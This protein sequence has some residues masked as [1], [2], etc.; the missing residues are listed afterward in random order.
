MDTNIGN[1]ETRSYHD[2]LGER[3][4]RIAAQRKER[5][6]EFPPVANV[7][8]GFTFIY[9]T[10]AYAAVGTEL[11]LNDLPEAKPA[12]DDDSG[13]DVSNADIRYAT[14]LKRL[15]E[16]TQDGWHV[17]MVVCLVMY[18]KDVKSFK[19]EVACMC[20][21]PQDDGVNAAMDNFIR[22]MA[23]RIKSG[24]HPGLGL[25]QAEFSRVIK[26]DGQWCLTKAAPLPKR[27][28]GV[29]VFKRKRTWTEYIVGFAGEHQRGCNL[30]AILFWLALIALIVFI[31][32]SVFFR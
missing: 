28:D 24:D 7:Y 25:S 11:S 1:N 10:E 18:E 15:Q 29:M 32:W 2:A 27:K 19:A 6:K 26:S 5:S 3:A 16:H 4:E 8:D 31:V 21:C 14:Q 12:N 13:E 23:K 9:D 30:L 22:N 17:H 20:Y